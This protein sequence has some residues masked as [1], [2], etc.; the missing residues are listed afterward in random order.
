[1]KMNVYMQNVGI[2]GGGAAGMFAAVNLKTLSPGVAV[3]VLEAGTRVLAKVAVTGGGRCNLTNTF[4][5]VRSME[6]VYPR[7]AR[8]MKRLMYGF[9]ERDTRTWFENHGIPLAVRKDFDPDC[10]MSER[11]CVFPASQDAMTIVNSLTHEARKRGVE[12][13]TSQPVTAV[14]AVGGAYR[15]TAAGEERTFDQLLIATGGLSPKTRAALAPLELPIVEPVPSLFTFNLPESPLRELTGTVADPVTVGLTGT[16][17]R[18]EGALLVTHWGVSGPA[19]LRLSSYAARLLAER[20][21][22]AELSINWLHDVRA[23]EASARLASQARQTPQKLLSSVSP[24]V[25]SRR[26]WDYILQK[27]GIPAERRWAEAGARQMNRLAE[28]LTNDRHG[29]A[30]QSRFKE[31]FVTCGGIDLSAVSSQLESRRHPGLFFAGEVLDI[32]GVTGGF[33]LQAAWTTGMTAA[34]AMEAILRRR[35]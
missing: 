13:V 8:L 22:L 21:Y 12:I 34:R 1:M 7:G 32:D 19:V 25:L 3:T 33:N 4:A 29:I 20:D 31:E 10:S 15:V 27:A 28:V 18:A 35:S 16:K 5:G 14:E 23:E 2:I 17:L 11:E 26:L 6:E 30:G 24:F 9:S